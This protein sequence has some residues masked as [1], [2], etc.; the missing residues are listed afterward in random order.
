[1]VS[2]VSYS[3]C[4]WG[5]LLLAVA[6]LLS[7]GRGAIA[8]VVLDWNA[9]M[10][11]AIRLDNTGP[12]LSTRNLAILHLALYDAVNSIE[13]THQAYAV[14]LEPGGPA[15]MEAAAAAAGYEVLKVL[16]PGVRAR[17]DETYEAWRSG[18]PEDTATVRGI[19]LGTEVARRTLD[20]RAG[21]GSATDVPYIPSNDPGQ[22]RRTPPFFRPPLTP[23]WRHV[24]LF[25][26]PE[27]EPFVPPP[28]PPLESAVY[29]RD[30]NEVR[31]LG[32]RNSEV[33]TE[34]QRL[35]AVFWSDFSYTAMPPGHWHEIA[36]GIARSAGIDVGTTARL[37]A[38][39]SLA[40]ADSAIVC[41]EAKFRYNLWRPVTAIQRAD[42][43]G[44]PGTEKDPAWDHLLAAPPFPAYTSGHSTFSKASAEVLA[45]F[46]GTDAITFTA[47][48]DSVPGVY[49]TY[50]SLSA[51][52]D[53]VGMSRI[54]GGIHFGFDNR[55][56]KASGARVA[57]HVVDNW[58]LPLDRLPFVCA[59]RPAPGE[60]RVRVHGRPGTRVVL[61]AS[62]NLLEWAAISTNAPVAGGVRVTLPATGTGY[63]FFRAVE[64]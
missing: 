32:A 18:A 30:L 53:E 52:A 35:I 12:T 27:L 61:E 59:E 42:E 55:S 43:D 16:Y 19:A 28:P 22:W 37:M 45:S 13:R 4:N 50:D 11:A 62:S 57:R 15:S 51:C 54:Y 58:L 20:S 63:R 44:N 41:W 9:V 48:S 40:Q 38:L 1:M 36:A 10:M 56:G 29:A 3:W 8:N 2:M 5:R 6:L 33:R 21:D 7:A 25:A 23:G 39:L 17:A 47:A 49:R 46:F 31:V 14:E 64:Q 60:N 24:R 26:L 34:E